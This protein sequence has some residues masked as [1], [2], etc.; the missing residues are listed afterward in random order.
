VQTLVAHHYLASQSKERRR[1]QRA[2]EI[3]KRTSHT[4][5]ISLYIPPVLAFSAVANFSADE[6]TG[7]FPALKLRNS[8]Q[9]RRNHSH[10]SVV[11]KV[12]TGIDMLRVTPSGASIGSV[13]FVFGGVLKVAG[14]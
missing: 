8:K 14:S 9:K 12:E 2:I 13:S 7:V 6:I 1:K 11:Q 4:L 3:N 10:R 5:K